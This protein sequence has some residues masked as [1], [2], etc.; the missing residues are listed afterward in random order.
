MSHG[1]FTDEINNDDYFHRVAA[2]LIPGVSHINKFGSNPDV[3]T[4]STPEAIWDVGGL[5][6][7]PTIGRIHDIVSTNTNDTSA[8]TGARTVRVTGLDAS[9]NEQTEDVT[10]NGTTNVATANTYSRIFRMN[11]L[12]AGSNG[13]NFGQI[14]ATAQTDGTITARIRLGNG[15][16]LMAI[17]TIPS[18]KT[19]FMTG[20]YSN[21]SKISAGQD[22]NCTMRLEL[23]ANADQSD[24][25]QGIASIWGMTHS[26]NS[27]HRHSFHPFAVI[28]EKTDIVMICSDITT[29]NND[30]SGGYDIILVDNV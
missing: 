7:P 4:S 23:T 12:T 17:Y 27:E 16:T 15:T 25:A 30:I 28:P 9:F 10:M 18:G 2:G 11:V 1:L 24:S 8:G 22:P 20:I 3:D 19:G 29:I 26:G 13:T 5:Y 6:V 14:D 21:L